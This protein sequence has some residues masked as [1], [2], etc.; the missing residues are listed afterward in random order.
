MGR[1]KKSSSPMPTGVSW[2]S[3]VPLGRC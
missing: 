2:W 1:A 3:V